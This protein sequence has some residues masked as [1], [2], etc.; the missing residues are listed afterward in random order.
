MRSTNIISLVY[1]SALYACAETEKQ[2]DKTSTSQESE[3][4]ESLLP[5]SYVLTASSSNFSI[6][7]TEDTAGNTTGTVEDVATMFGSAL[8]I[9][10]SEA[11]YGVF[12]YDNT[13]ESF[14]GTWEY[15]TGG[16]WTPILSSSDIDT[17]IFVS[18]SDFL[19]FNPTGDYNRS[20]AEQAIDFKALIN[21]DTSSPVHCAS[22]TAVTGTA[23]DVD[24]PNQS[25]HNNCIVAESVLTSIVNAVNDP[26]VFSGTPVLD[27]SS[28]DNFTPPGD[29][30]SNL[31][32]S[33]FDDSADVVLD[34]SSVA[35]TDGTTGNALSGIVVVANTADSSTQ[36]VW[37]YRL[38]N[39]G[40]WGAIADDITV[41]GSNGLLLNTSAELRFVPV[42]D[43]TGAPTGLDVH[44]VEDS[45]SETFTALKTSPVVYDFTS[46]T[47]T[48]VSV[49]SA[50]LGT[51]ISNIA[52][53]PTF[54]SITDL[55]ISEDQAGSD[56]TGTERTVGTIL[57]TFISDI[58]GDSL[59]G[60]AISGTTSGTGGHWEYKLSGGSW[61]EI[62]NTYT[63][64]AALAITVSDY[65]RFVPDTDFNK[66]TAVIPLTV[67]PIDDTAASTV[68]DAVVS[69]TASTD[70]DGIG[71]S[72]QTVS[73]IVAPINDAPTLT[74]PGNTGV[75]K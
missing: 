53:D 52:D 29:T 21:D 50:T 22:L 45:F 38:S 63:D 11:L 72:S 39:A 37:E 1:F 56:I 57:S 42:G 32:S 13:A 54:S 15:S 24:N 58:D 34:D 61:A 44:L 17:A 68:Y 35:V 3:E 59:G 18:G 49:S 28:E 7:I 74:G 66:T 40:V 5:D 8:T 65:I 70:T 23:Y 6:T 10:A 55:T 31:F 48:H 51:T 69:I 64:L 16:A 60:I 20:S 30:V 25:F 47:D 71:E 75:S 33:V 26:P 12:V 62:G 41:S 46:L 36:G 19:R 9:G 73:V 27:P 43:F 67:Y 2:E 14:E 4:R